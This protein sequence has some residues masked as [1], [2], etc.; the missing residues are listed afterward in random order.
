MLHLRARG[1]APLTRGGA[2]VRK[3]HRFRRWPCGLDVSSPQ[4]ASRHSCA[5]SKKSCV[6]PE[7][8]CLYPSRGPIYLSGQRVTKTLKRMVFTDLSILSFRFGYPGSGPKVHPFQGLCYSLSA[9]KDWTPT[10]A[11]AV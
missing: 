10:W 1:F 8:N 6:Q 9:R 4:P 5:L 11:E 2:N 3:F 7:Q